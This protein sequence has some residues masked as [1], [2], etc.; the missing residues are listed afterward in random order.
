MEEE[1]STVSKQNLVISLCFAA[2]VITACSAK[3]S[4]TPPTIPGG[5]GGPR[6]V[7]NLGTPEKNVVPGP[8][9]KGRYKSDCSTTPDAEVRAPDL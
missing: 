7:G 5:G 8:E 9:L 1:M 4:I 2:A 6:T 3:T